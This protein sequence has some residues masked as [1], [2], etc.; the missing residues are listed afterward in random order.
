MSAFGQAPTGIINGNVTDETGAVI[1]NATVTI[2]NKATGISRTA[3]SN[4]EGLYTAVALPAAEYEVRCEAKGFRTVIREATVTA[5]STTLVSMPMTVG[6]TQEVVTVEAATAQVNYENNQITGSIGRETIQDLP[7]NGRSYMQLASLEPGVTI[8]TG[9]VAQFNVLF[10]VSVLGSGNRT[11]YTIDG[12]NVSDNID[13][14][15]GISSMN[16]SQEVVQEFQ[17]S[18]SNFDISTPIAAGGAINV[19]TRS[20]SNDFHGG[21]YFFYRDHNMA[22]YPNLGRIADQPSPFFTRKNPGGTLGGPIKKDKIFFFFNYEYMNQVQAVAIQTTDPAF[23]NLQGSYP[24]PYHQDMISGRIDYHIS[25]KHTA[26][27]RY[28]HDGNA[29]FGQ[30]LIDGDPSSFAHN[31]N[32]S[33]QGILGLTSTFTAT[34]VNDARVQYNYWNNHNNQAV[35]SDCSLPCVAGA[36]PT[37]FTFVGSDFPAVGPN[38]NAPQGRNTR[39]Y[40]FVDGLS[41]QKGTHRVKFGGD[42]NPTTSAGEWGFCTPMCL[43]AFSPTY[44]RGA[45]TPAIGAAGVNAYFPTLP[46]VLTSDLGV[47]NLPVLLYP[48]SIFSGIGV[49]SISTPAPYDENQNTHFNQWRMYVQDTW[50]VRHNLTLNYGLAWN[51]QTGFYNSDLPLP[52]YLAPLVGSG[53]LGAT[54]NNTKEFQPAFG[55]AWSPF[56]NNKT[57][58]RGGGG[59]YWDSTPGYYKLR[60]APVVGPLGDG[61]ETLAGSAFTNIYPGIINFATGQPV[62][63]GANF[64]LSGLL[65]LTVGQ[66]ENI[67]NQELPSISAKLFPSNVQK[68]GPYT[69]T[70]IDVAKQGVEIYPNHFPLARSYQTSLGIQHDLGHGIVASADWARR[71]GENTSLGEVDLNHFGYDVNGTPSPVIPVCTTA[72]QYVPGQECSTGSITFWTDEGRSIYN[73]L[74]V[75]VTGRT[76]HNKLHM[77][78]GYAYQRLWT[79]QPWNTLNYMAGWGQVLNHQNLNIALTYN[80]PWG[81]DISM[82]SAMISRSP[83]EPVDSSLQTA[84]VNLGTSPYNY[85]ALPGLPYDCLGVSCGKAQLAAAV[86]AFNSTYAGTKGA[87]GA[88]I[89]PLTLPANYSIGQ[90]LLSQDFR[91]TKTFTFKERYR[92]SILGELFNAFNISNETIGNYQ[93]GPT[94]GQPN[95]RIGQTFGSGGP[96]AAQ[97]G[98]RFAF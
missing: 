74:L 3:T 51:A 44:V 58:V 52:Q 47:L 53:N 5:G 9:T 72:Q 77:Q 65:N 21:L 17:L 95:G 68:S 73:G 11:V 62:P 2:T 82:N 6:G 10:T 80:L 12:G 64:P 26:F 35:P 46:T 27:L 92:F 54:Q 32:W 97:V 85:E 76:M 16:F 49:G 38:F 34:L 23:V 4:A 78:V 59:I 56:K 94:F 71:Q 8:S 67:V 61:R 37:I 50:K 96:R 55:F 36:L 66:F 89:A 69:V 79:D 63:V 83:V 84:G 25:D 30:S 29:G 7:L 88:T 33:D 48:S 31:T 18:S 87:N 57:V 13:T 24:S 93:I 75:K 19:V 70:G 43:G 98:A 41:W 91:L 20:G 28:S 60:D 45:L 42:L 15:G 14:G 81:F 39:R 86:T 40:E 22:A 90:P 1:P